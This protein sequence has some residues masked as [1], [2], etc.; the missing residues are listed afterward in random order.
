MRLLLAW[1]QAI[2]LTGI[3]EPGAVALGHVVDSLTAVPV[4]RSRGV[5]RLLDLGSGG[6]FPGLPLA[7]ALPVERALLV[8]SIAKK[9]GFLRT[10]IDATGLAAHVV[11]EAARAESLARDPRDREAWA[12]V[13]TR[14]VAPLG[15]L[16]EVG[17]PLVAPGGVLVA[18]K[19]EPFDAELAAAAPALAALRAGR[20]DVVDPRVA[21][22]ERHRLVVVER[23]GPLDA[24]LSQGCGGAQAPAVVKAAR[25]SPRP[26]ALRY[27]PPMRVAVLSDLHANIAALEAV[28]AVMPSVDEVWHLGDVVGYGPQ[29]DAVVARLREI[30]ARGVR[31]NHDAA[32]VGQLDIEAFNVDAR[33]AMEWTRSTIADETRAWLAAL[34]ERLEREDFLLVHGSPRDPTWEYITTIPVARAGMAAMP[35]RSGLHGHTHV[36]IAF[37]EDDG[38]LDTMSPGA[39]SHLTF[40][41]RRVLLNPG[42]VGQPR[43]G[44]PTTS[45]LLLDTAEGSATW[46]RT[47]YDVS[48]VQAEMLALGLPDRLIERLSYGL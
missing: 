34:P 19:R 40:D 33:G 15:E 16:V 14:A 42:S 46:Q 4:L 27:A 1:T 3:R 8:D 48:S 6:G 45:W 2:N 23:G 39:G 18:W 22:L 26:F 28:L 7:A 36:P 32:A 37:V 29:P 17:L 31:G 43:D 13:V 21:G 9:V 44:I 24:G 47:A 30:G 10:V 5:T 38:R 12:A 41:G 11:A 20:V 25:P 35:T